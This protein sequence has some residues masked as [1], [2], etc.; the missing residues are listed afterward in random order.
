M[1]KILILKLIKKKVH[2]HI[3]HQIYN[4]SSSNKCCL[5]YLFIIKSL[6]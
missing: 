6:K 2:R 3:M 4:I 1:L 5:Y